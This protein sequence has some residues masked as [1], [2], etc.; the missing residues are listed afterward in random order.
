M[1]RPMLVEIS[2]QENKFNM[3][4]NV[5]SAKIRLKYAQDHLSLA[6]TKIEEHHFENPT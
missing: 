6:E 3:F 1:E 5:L 4:K 2:R